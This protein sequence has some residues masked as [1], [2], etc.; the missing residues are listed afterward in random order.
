MEGHLEDISRTNYSRGDIMSSNLINIVDQTWLARPRGSEWKLFLGVN[1]RRSK[2]IASGKYKVTLNYLDNQGNVWGETYIKAVGQHYDDYSNWTAKQPLL[3]LAYSS[4]VPT[5]VPKPYEGRMFKDAAPGV[6]GLIGEVVVTTFLQKVLKLNTFNIAHLKSNHT[7]QAPD[8]CLDIHPS[9]ISNLL[10][11]SN[12]SDLINHLASSQWLEPLPLECKGRK[13]LSINHARAAL[14]QII[15]YW[16]NVPSMAGCGLF[17]QIDI[18]PFTV[19]NI[20]LL[21][22]KISKAQEIRDIVLGN[23]SIPTL[24]EYPTLNEFRRLIGGRLYE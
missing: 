24:S 13:S 12:R 9:V 10:K 3:P 19:I 14:S 23:T 22:P 21:L 11:H 2:P 5:F 8:F 7:F 15:T 20:H 6:T 18:L 4:A 1:S 16:R 17:A